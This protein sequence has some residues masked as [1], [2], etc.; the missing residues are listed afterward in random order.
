MESGRARIQWYIGRD[1]NGKYHVR[2]RYY[3]SDGWGDWQYDVRP[4]TFVLERQRLIE[5]GTDWNTLLEGEWRKP[6]PN[7]D[8]DP[9]SVISDS[10]ITP[11]GVLRVMNPG[12]SEMDARIQMFF[13]YSG[14]GV[15]SV[16]L[17]LAVSGRNGCGSMVAK[18]LNPTRF[19]IEF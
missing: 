18:S 6:V 7:S 13:A 5:H 4:E 9:N 3:G 12:Y 14:Q 8:G 10:G 16:Q 17:M 15:F 19:A 11:I 2:Y 1:L